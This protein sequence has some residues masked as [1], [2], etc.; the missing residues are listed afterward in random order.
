MLCTPQHL[1]KWTAEIQIAGETFPAEAAHNDT[2]KDTVA[3]A[4]TEIGE[5]MTA[6][7]V[8]FQEATLVLHKRLAGQEPRRDRSYHVWRE[9]GRVRYMA[10]GA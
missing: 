5:L 3:A 10:M 9:N 7:L 2:L 6:G 4:V 1:R 8:P